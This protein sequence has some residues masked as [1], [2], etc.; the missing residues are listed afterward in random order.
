MGVESDQLVFD[1]LSR[2]GDLAQTA[3]PAS[4]RMRLVTQLR[5]DIE[6]ERAGS[7]SAATV[8][9]ILSKLGTPDEVVEAAAGGQ[10]AA[11][12]APEPS[13]PVG[14][15]AARPTL[16]PSAPAPQ[17][18]DGPAVP[19]RG[20]SDEWWRVPSQRPEPGVSSSVRTNEI[21]AGWSGGL[22]P[23][24]P[25]DE[26][27]ETADDA[28]EPQKAAAEERPGKAAVLRRVFRRRKR[29]AAAQQPAAVRRRGLPVG[30]L[31]LLA[32]LALVA[33]VVLAN[34]LA[35]GIGW[36][37]AYTTRGV[38]R[39]E[40]KFAAMG[41]PGLVVLG[42]LVWLWGRTAGR[43]GR[44]IPDGTLG[45]AISADFPV[46]VKVAALASAAFLLWRSARR[47]RG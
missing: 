6:R 19:V 33:G 14:R 41:M 38:T 43:W 34:W 22:L 23:L 12:S 10:A 36:L 26:A 2:V 31:E 5:T 32:A 17:A 20:E 25:D 7:E 18:V 24:E 11:L 29:A 15:A 35:L 9:R 1:Y 3:L 21:L 42:M 16:E 4:Q 40:A 39:T 13:A 27:E 37:I 28:E 8:R 44:P 30:P 47:R 45:R 46:V